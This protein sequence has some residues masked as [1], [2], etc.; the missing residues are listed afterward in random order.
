MIVGYHQI[1]IDEKVLQETESY[2]HDKETVRKYLVN[3]KH[4]KLTTLYYLL[5]LKSINAGHKSEADI[6]S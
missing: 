1:P 6:S 5:L 4:N 3:N 2:G